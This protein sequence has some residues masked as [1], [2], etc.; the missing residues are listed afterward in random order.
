MNGIQYALRRVHHGETEV[1]GELLRIAEVHHADHEVHHVSRDL[2]AWSQDHV[3]LL[4]DHAARHDLD[5]DEEADAPRTVVEHLRAA[6][7]TVLGRRPEPGLL[8]LEDLANLYRLASDN[9]LAWEM[10]A[11]IAQAQREQELLALTKKCHP[12]NLRQLRWANSMIKILT[13]QTL[14]SM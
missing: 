8:L 11:Q 7:S 14:S 13:P 9:S 1:A 4:A 3:R 10:L 2:A 6:A 5:L 12:Q